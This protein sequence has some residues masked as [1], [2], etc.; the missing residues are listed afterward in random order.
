MK[1]SNLYCVSD[2]KYSLSN[3]LKFGFIVTNE[4]INERGKNTIIIKEID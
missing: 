2:I 1:L 4:H 3:M